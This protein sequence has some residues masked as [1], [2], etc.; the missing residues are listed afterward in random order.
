MWSFLS[1]MASLGCKS[2]Q[3]VQ[4]PIAAH[5]WAKL[6]SNCYYCYSREHFSANWLSVFVTPTLVSHNPFLV[7]FWNGWRRPV[8]KPRGVTLG[9][10]RGNLQKKFNHLRLLQLPDTLLKRRKLHPLCPGKSDH[11][12]MSSPSNFYQLQPPRCLGKAHNSGLLS[13]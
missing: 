6:K 7:M 2:T 8:K 1:S 12:W 11:K 9:T 4:G 5:I 13:R 10:A 3:S